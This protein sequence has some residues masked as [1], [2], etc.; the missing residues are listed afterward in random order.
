MFPYW[1]TW[2]SPKFFPW[3]SLLLSLRDQ[4]QPSWLV[5]LM[6]REEIH[7]ENIIRASFFPFPG[8][9]VFTRGFLCD[10]LQEGGKF[11][12][13]SRLRRGAPSPGGSS[14]REGTA[15]V[16]CQTP[17]ENS[18]LIWGRRQKAVRAWRDQSQALNGW[19]GQGLWVTDSVLWGWRG[20]Y[21]WDLSLTSAFIL[22]INLFFNEFIF[23]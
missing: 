21:S 12:L 17:G 8:L 16:R 19:V 14:I 10:P 20:R 5:L 6:F 4:H 7:P 9:G 22:N 1:A 18:S 2:Y 3:P 13:D 15:F 23:R 11:N